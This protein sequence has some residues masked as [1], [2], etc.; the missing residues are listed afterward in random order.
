VAYANVQTSGKL[1]TSSGAGLS[2]TPAGAPT[3]NNLLTGRFFGWAG[4]AG[5]VPASTDTKDSNGTPVN[6][7]L[8]TSGTNT[9][10]IG[11]AIYSLVVP[12]GLTTPLKNTNTVTV[13]EGVFD[14]WSGNATTSVFDVT[15]HNSDVTNV[16]S[17]TSGSIN[18]GANAGLALAVVA[19]GGGGST[20]TITT[21][22]TSFV[23]D[24]TE[25]D[26]NNW[27]AGSADSRT[28]NVA[29]QT[30]LQDSW[31]FAIAGVFTATIASYNAPA[32][33]AAAAPEVHMSPAMMCGD[34]AMAR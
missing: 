24:I 33:G 26:N 19:Q 27:Q 13:L 31:T 3:L 12:S 9:N 18:T 22:G 2:W 8:N 14:E 20:D 23:N 25:P 32:G 29:A 7:A 5:Y 34:M 15:S 6:Y 28:V 1:R 4:G 21:T 17:G 16:T 10:G 11:T 30:G